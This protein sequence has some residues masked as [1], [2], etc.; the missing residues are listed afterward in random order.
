MNSVLNDIKKLVKEHEKNDKYYVQ[1]EEAL[2]KAQEELE[3]LNQELIGCNHCGCSMNHEVSPSKTKEI[4][5]KEEE[6]S[7]IEDIVWYSKYQFCSQKC[8]EYNNY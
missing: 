2:D 3:E 6:I 4:E 5:E 8:T 7:I 1:L